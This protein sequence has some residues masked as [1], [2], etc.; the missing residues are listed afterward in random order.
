MRSGDLGASGDRLIARGRVIG[1]S[2]AV[3]ESCGT[4]AL[5]CVR[6]ARWSVALLRTV[7]ATLREIFDENAYD[8]FLLRTQEARSVDSY[9][10]FMRERE[11]GMAKRPRC[12]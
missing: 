12:C 2:G 5:S 9:R 10:K 8:R 4:A 6:G 7:R 3:E 11:A 1:K